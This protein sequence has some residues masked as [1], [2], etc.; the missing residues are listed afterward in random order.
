M[1]FVVSSSARSVRGLGVGEEVGAAASEI[2]VVEWSVGSGRVG[3]RVVGSDGARPR[4]LR[5][6]V[7]DVCMSEWRLRVLWSCG[8]LAI[9]TVWTAA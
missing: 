7:A 4:S 5:V 8:R 6:R 3:G 2:G 9:L 1:A